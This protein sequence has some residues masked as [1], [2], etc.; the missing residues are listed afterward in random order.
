[1]TVKIHF[2]EAD[3]KF[4]QLI[5]TA[6]MKEQKFRENPCWPAYLAKLKKEGV[7]HIYLEKQG[8]AYAKEPPIGKRFG[9]IISVDLEL[10]ILPEDSSESIL[11]NL[12]VISSKTGLREGQNSSSRGDSWTKSGRLA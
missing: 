2:P 6:I 4:M 7:S 10:E 3:K 11:P 8:I 5:E 1:M 12:A 9:E